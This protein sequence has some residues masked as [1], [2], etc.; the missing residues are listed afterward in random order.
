MQSFL[1]KE[2]K[3]ND[4]WIINRK[5]NYKNILNLLFESGK[6]RSILTDNRLTMTNH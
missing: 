1:F 6:K 2:L 5:S 3:Y 4:E